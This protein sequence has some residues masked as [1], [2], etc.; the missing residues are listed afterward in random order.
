[1]VEVDESYFG[2]TRPHQLA[3]VGKLK[4]ERTTLKQPVFGLFERDGRISYT[5]VVPDSSKPTLQRIIG[6]KVALESELVSDS[7]QGSGRD[8]I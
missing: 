1:M 8:R 7:W 4:P 5:E 6:A 2:A 3:G